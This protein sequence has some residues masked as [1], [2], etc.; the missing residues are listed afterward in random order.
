MNFCK[1]VVQG[2]GGPAWRRL[3]FALLCFVAS[4]VVTYVVPYD[5]TRM[6]GLA[7]IATTAF[8]ILFGFSLT[9]IAVV[10]GLDSVLASFS[11]ES[12]QRYKAT[13]CAKILRQC[14]LCLSYFVALLLALALTALEQRSCAHIVV[15]RLFV[16]IA[17]FSLLASFSMPFALCGLYS[18]RYEL[19][20]EGKGAPK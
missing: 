17:C 18:E 8:S 3:L 4:G 15:A 11:W 16:F 14:A 1:P 20:M 7:N 19:L 10:G 2:K 12:L 9:I 6:D 13:F 5:A